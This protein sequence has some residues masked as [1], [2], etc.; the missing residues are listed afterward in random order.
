M[1]DGIGTQ[2][3]N[4]LDS[5]V[6]IIEKGAIMVV[7][8]AV[9]RGAIEFKRIVEGATPVSINGGGELRN[10]I[11]LTQTFNNGRYGYRLQFLGYTERYGV[12]LQLIA[13]TLNTGRPAGISDTGRGYGAIE[14]IKFINNALSRLAEINPE[15]QSRMKIGG[16]SITDTHLILNDGSRIDL[17]DLENYGRWIEKTQRNRTE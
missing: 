1:A 5:M 16:W 3:Q 7:I 17:S 9:D 2:I 11:E 4:Y 8:Q 10:S 6:S 13:N 12:P 14:G 15:I